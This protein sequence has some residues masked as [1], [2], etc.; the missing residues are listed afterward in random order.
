MPSDFPVDG[1]GLVK[2]DS[3]DGNGTGM[4]VSSSGELVFECESGFPD[5][6]AVEKAAFAGA[7]F[8]KQSG[9][10]IVDGFWRDFSRKDA[11]ATDLQ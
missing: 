2:G 11:I 1:C 5:G 9:A 6:W 3:L 10:E 7:V 4:K 8:S